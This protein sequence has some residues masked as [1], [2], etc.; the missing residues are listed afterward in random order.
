MPSR[1]SAFDRWR[2]IVSGMTRFPT[3]AL[4]GAFGAA[5]LLAACT[6]ESD[7]RPDK[8]PEVKPVYEDGKLGE[9]SGDGTPTKPA[10]ATPPAPKPT[11]PP[12]TPPTTPPTTPPATPPSAPPAGGASAAAP[13]LSGS[14]AV[15]VTYLDRSMIPP[16]CTVEAKLVDVSKADAPAV[17]LAEQSLESKGGPPFGFTLTYD[18]GKI[19]PA[20][21]YAVQA[22]I[23]KDGKLLYVS[24]TVNAVLTR[25]APTDKIEVIVK[26]QAG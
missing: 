15:N 12:A 2:G 19:D 5:L 10:A 24:D 11:T 13:A 26:K 7:V 6:K 18:K 22:R 21:S 17:T 23:S 14:L 20:H 3:I 9:T 8:G 4:A 25:G 1:G 16:A